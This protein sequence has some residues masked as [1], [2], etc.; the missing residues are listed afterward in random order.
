MRITKGSIVK[1]LLLIQKAFLIVPGTV[2]MSFV[3][4]SY[5]GRRRIREYYVSVR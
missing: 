3:Y 4:C 2:Y 5:I 1:Q